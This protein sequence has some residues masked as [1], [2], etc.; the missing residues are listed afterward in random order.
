RPYTG[1]TLQYKIDIQN[2]LMENEFEVKLYY[3]I[4]AMGDKTTYEANKTFLKE[5][6]TI[7]I[8]KAK[9]LIKD[10]HIPEFLRPGEYIINVK[11]E[12][13]GL[14]S[15]SSARF[16]VAEPF[17]DFL[18]LGIFP[19]RW[20]IFVSIIAIALIALFL[21]IKKRKESKKRYKSD[22]DFKLLPKPGER[23]IFIGKIAETNVKAYFDLDQLSIH[24]LIAGST[25]GGKTVSAEVLVEEALKKNVGVIVFDPTAQWSGFLRKCANKKM[26]EIYADFGMKKSDARAFNGNVHQILDA[27]QIIEI[28]K[29]M[30]PG[31]I[32]VFATNKLDPRDMDILV[33]NTIREVFS[34]NL[35]ESQ[36]LKTII[37]F[38]EVHRLLPKFGGSGEGFI[39]IERGAREFRKWG[40]GLILISQVLTD[41]IGETKANINT[42]IQMR[43]RDEGDLNRIKNKY[44][45][46]M[47]QSLLK[48]ATGTGMFE[49]SAYNKGNPYFV[50]LRPLLHEHAR[51]SDEELENYNKYNELIEDLEYQ[52]EQLEELK[53]DVFDLRL[54]LKMALDKVKSGSFNMVDIYLE[55]LTPRIK[56]QWEK[57]GKTPKQRKIKLVSEEELKREFEKAKKE[58]EKL[59]GD[60]GGIGSAKKASKASMQLE[61][62]KLKNGVT[63]TSIQEL[64]D[65]INTMDDAA[66][67]QHVNEKENIFADWIGKADQNIA[68]RIK[69]S[70]TKED[71][72]ANLEDAL[73]G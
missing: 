70:K 36:E 9:T 68:K 13:L 42:E 6:E 73:Y 60:S 53:I 10:F 8:D 61:A 50:S 24:A 38:D 64:I 39:Q 4:D 31:E 20:V 69:D 55:G 7:K 46:Y 56:S 62:L 23:S 54:E 59:G 14:T 48:S 58:R 22:V 29:Y 71:V 11:A 63:V 40:V 34:A 66:F 25:G 32:H 52:I 49:N 33:A 1:Q 47:L 30:I 21:I 44:G 41:F 65:S 18:I 27:R 5:E 28:K 35:P 26:M 43:T 45:G 72:I 16:Y 17:W 2:L 57:L 19:V 37:I 3:S 15:V 12:Y 51:L 67:K